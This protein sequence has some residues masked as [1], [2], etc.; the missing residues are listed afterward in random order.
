MTD[1]KAAVRIASLWLKPT[2]DVVLNAIGQAANSKPSDDHQ[3]AAAARSCDASSSGRDVNWLLKNVA[4]NLILP[5]RDAVRFGM[6]RVST[7]RCARLLKTTARISLQDC[8]QD[9]YARP[10]KEMVFELTRDGQLKVEGK[11]YK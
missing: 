7:G 10:P 1:T 3:V 8:L 5:S 11:K 4:V 9:V 6:L 2:L